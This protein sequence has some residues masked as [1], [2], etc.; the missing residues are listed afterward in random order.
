MESPFISESAVN[1]R[2][3]CFKHLNLENASNL[4][5]RKTNGVT[6]SFWEGDP[7]IALDRFAERSLLAVRDTFDAITRVVCIGV[8]LR[9]KMSNYVVAYSWAPRWARS[10]HDDL[11]NGESVFQVE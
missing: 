6:D 1:N 5:S 10:E 8:R 11:T 4:D 2:S 9:Y 3:I 7:L